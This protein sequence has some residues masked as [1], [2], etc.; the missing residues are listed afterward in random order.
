M[1][2]YFDIIFALNSLT[3]PGEKRLAE[4]CRQSCKI[5]PADFEKNISDLFENLF[6]DGEKAEHILRA[7]VKEITVILKRENYF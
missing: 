5:L 4:L 1:E 3:H 2:S 6:T 7:M